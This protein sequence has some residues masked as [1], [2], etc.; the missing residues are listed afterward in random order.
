MCRYPDSFFLN[1]NG[2]LFNDTKVL[3]LFNVI[4][5]KALKSTS[6]VYF[7]IKRDKESRQFLFVMKSINSF[8]HDALNSKRESCIVKDIHK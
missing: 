7:N 4:I 2:A 6:M 3:R 1:E 8:V 5:V